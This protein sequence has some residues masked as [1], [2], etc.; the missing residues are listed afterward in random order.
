M[1]LETW[2]RP[3][4]LASIATNSFGEQ[5]MKLMRKQQ[6]EVAGRAT[7]QCLGLKKTG[8]LV[9]KSKGGIVWFRYWKEILLAKLI[10]FAK[11]SQKA[12][13]DTLVQE[14]NAPAHAHQHQGKVG[15][16]PPRY[17]SSSLA[18]QQPRPQSYRESL[19]LSQTSHDSPE[20][21]VA[22]LSK[23]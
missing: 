10:P 11:E 3:Q 14:D 5:S 15:I 18:W 8:K 4:N 2:N 9:R 7:V 19:V 1:V 12:R 21:E 16:C 22:W 17:R 6:S 23:S 13:P 20:M